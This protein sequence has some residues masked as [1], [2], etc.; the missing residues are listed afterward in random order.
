MQSQAQW[1]YLFANDMPFARRWAHETPGGKKRR[2]RRLPVKKKAYTLDALERYVTSPNYDPQVAQI[3]AGQI[4][5]LPRYKGEQIAPGITRIRGNL[6]NVH[7]RY[8]PCDEAGSAKP[9][10]VPKPAK[11]AAKPKPRRGRGGGGKGGAAAKPKKT[12]EQRAAEQEAKR[13]QRQQE[14]EA[15]RQEQDT[16]KRQ[17]RD[18]LLSDAGLDNQ[19][20]DALVDARAGDMLAPINGEKL[21]KMGLAEQAEDGSYRL[22]AA[23]RG[24]VDAALRGDAGKVN[25]TIS[26]A[27]DAAAKRG[28]K[29][30]KGG[31]GGG[32]GKGGAAKPEKPSD[33]EKRQ[34]RDQKRQQTAAETAQQVALPDGA[35]EVLRAAAEGRT[36]NI[37]RG[38]VSG[39]INALLKLGLVTEGDTTEATDQGRRALAALERGDVRGYQAALQDAK[40]RLGRESAAQTRRQAV[41]QRQQAAE[42]QRTANRQAAADRRHAAERAALD[43]RMEQQRRREEADKRRAER[44]AERRRR[45]KSFRVFKDAAGHWRWVAISSTAYQD[46]D[47]EIVSTKALTEDCTRADATGQYGPLRWWHAP[48]LNLGDCDFNAMDGRVLIESGTFKTE[49]I[50][51]KVAAHADQLEVSLGFIHPS[52]EPDAAGVF[53][54][55]RRFERSLT[56]RGKASNL[57]TS[58][59]VKETPMIDAIKKKALE[60]LGFS[61]ADITALEQ[62]SAATQKT[63]DEAGVTFKADEPEPETPAPPEEIT[64][65]GVVYTVKAPPPPEPPV[66]AAKDDGVGDMEVMAEEPLME[67]EPTSG[68]TLT[69]EDLQALGELIGSTLQSALGPLVQ[70]LNVVNTMS[71]GLGELKT[72]MGGYATAETKKDAERAEQ[73]EQITKLDQRL[74]E[75]EGDQPAVPY[76]PS[77]AAETRLNPLNPNDHALLTAI[78]TQGEEQQLS[79]HQFADITKLLF[80]NGQQP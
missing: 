10:T 6:C 23:G 33:E 45:G 34:E 14:Q 22:T 78:K 42:R 43:R 4:D 13:Q 2:F 51:R 21:A 68:L 17:T 9:T 16:A 74:K 48:S 80:G 7:G 60:V 55:I 27:R 5:E 26:A 36:P 54:H 69:P 71:S 31:S 65:N 39:V 24:A 52:T 47:G 41:S 67:E 32:G 29:P 62:Q 38:K 3:I 63:A 73:A 59:R 8:G 56:P 37:D 28:A 72:M 53:H 75:I 66:E 20:R 57:F 64:L 76:R 30:E 50:A 40:A 49:Q 18:K 70:A 19:T 61:E 1:R 25:D 15:K 77:Q 46:R 58:F 79:E 44:D 11:G 12:E 35:D